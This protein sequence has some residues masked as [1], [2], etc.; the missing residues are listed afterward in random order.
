[1]PDYSLEATRTVRFLASHGIP[2]IS[3]SSQALQQGA[4]FALGERTQ[5]E[6]RV[7]DKPQGTIRV[8]LPSRENQRRMASL[9][10]A[11]AAIQVAS[12]R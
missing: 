6:L 10:E 4:V 2:T 8:A 7:C 9:P 12:I 11:P 1:V 3:M 5:G